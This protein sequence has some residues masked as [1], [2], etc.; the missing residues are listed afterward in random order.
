VERIKFYWQNRPHTGWRIA[1]GI[2]LIALVLGF[3]WYVWLAVKNANDQTA[4]AQFTNQI[5]QEVAQ[6]RNT[7]E[8]YAN[9]LY[10]GRALLLTN[11]NASRADWTNFVD[12]QDIKQRYP[13][14]NGISY[15]SVVNRGEAGTL[16]AKL[17]AER[18]PSEQQ[19]ITIYPATTDD[20]LAVITYLAPENIK[21]QPIGY[22]MYSDQARRQT[23]DAARDT[24][25]PQASPPLQLISNQQGNSPGLLVVMPVYRP[26][27]MLSTVQARRAALSGYVVLS[28]HSQPLLDSILKPQTV[29]HDIA[30]NVSV[31]K[32]IIY[33]AGTAAPG[34]TLRKTLTVKMGGQKW[35]LT[36]SASPDYGLG[37][38][39][40]LAPQAI[41]LSA[42]PFT[43]II[44]VAF[45]YAM[46]LRALRFHHHQHHHA[47]G[48][49]HEHN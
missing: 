43:L 38:T 23:L 22:D 1:A 20:Q 18:L 9:A 44:G 8:I 13:G 39:A 36:F 6:L 27:G 26:D 10:S 41:L 16:T 4:D 3:R 37:T 19:P 30:L 47:Q 21:Q 48:S 31:G 17:N 25:Q 46:G 34:Q 28:L 33:Q 5:Q 35:R 2:L 11:P 40:L 42:I 29:L 45:Y 12:T 32:K 15:V 24:G 14:V 7:F 49:K